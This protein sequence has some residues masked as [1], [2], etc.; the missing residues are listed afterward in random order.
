[1]P[2]FNFFSW[3]LLFVAGA[4]LLWPVNVPLL[5]LA[6][7]VR[8]GQAPLGMPGREFWGRATFAALGLALLSLVLLGLTFALVSGAEFPRYLVHLVLF[9]IYVPVAAGF[10]FWIFALEDVFQGLSVFALFVLLAVPVV[11]LGARLLGLWAR[12][13]QLAPWILPTPG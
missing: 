8:H 3:C 7:K 5:A 12:L 4:T 6:F 13:E 1:M 9:L 11:A 2:L 10:L